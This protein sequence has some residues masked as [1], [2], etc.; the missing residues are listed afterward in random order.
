[1]QLFVKYVNS[2]Q[3]F[4]LFAVD[5]LEI[6]SV[7]SLNFI[8]YITE[9]QRTAKYLFTCCSKYTHIIFEILMVKLRINVNTN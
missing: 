1:M 5:M 6:T 8:V 3:L 9:S 2:K 7:I 4:V